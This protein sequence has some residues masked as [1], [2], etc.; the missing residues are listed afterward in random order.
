MCLRYITDYQQESSPTLF[1]LSPSS[2][3]AL[4]LGVN[5]G[6]V[7]K[8]SWSRYSFYDLLLEPNVRF[9][10]NAGLDIWT[11]VCLTVDTRRNL[12]QVFSGSNMSIRKMLPLEYVWSGEPV[13]DV[14]G[15]DGQ[16]TD[17]Q[18]WDYPIHYRQILDYMSNRIYESSPGSVLTWSSIGYSLRGDTLLEDTFEWQAKQSILRGGSGHHPGKERKN[19]KFFN[20]N[21]WDKKKSQQI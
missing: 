5:N 7:Y 1:T 16:V 21:R 17:L 2:R 20:H 3:S 6:G 13:I 8:L 12:A 9:W 10:S 19:R 4:T 18:M 11:R 14:S 15:F